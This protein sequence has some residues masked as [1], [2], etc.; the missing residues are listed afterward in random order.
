[1]KVLL[2]LVMLVSMTL[3]VQ[4]ADVEC[5]SSVCSP[6]QTR[7]VFTMG[8]YKACCDPFEFDYLSVT[9]RNSQPVCYCKKN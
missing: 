5:S 6:T 2:M 4:A 3:C 9:F 8:S 1:M 7:L